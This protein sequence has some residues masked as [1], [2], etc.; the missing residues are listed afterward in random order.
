MDG[1][2]RVW[3]ESVVGDEEHAGGADGDERRIVRHRADA[4]GRRG[5]VAAATGNDRPLRH[6][7][8]LRH[9][10][11]QPSRC[12]RTFVELRHLVDAHAAGGKQFGRPVALGDIEPVGA[13]RVRHVGGI[14]AR[15]AEAD[16]VLGQKHLCHLRKNLGLMLLH[17]Q[18]LRRGEAGKRDVAGNLAGARLRLLDVV[19][20]PEGTR[21]VPQ[22]AGPQ[23]LA[24]LAE[25]CRAMLLA[26][27]PDA[28]DRGDGLG[29]QLA[30]RLHHRV[31][32][33][34]PVLGVLLRPAGLRARD[35]QGGGGGG[36][37]LLP[38]VD[39][40]ALHR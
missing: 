30:Q 14:F 22:N 25:Q 2:A 7:P 37:D 6:A 34:P 29:L 9:M 40:D 20:F 26:G 5:I 38:G 17:P 36:D 35:L 27:Q 39:Q 24:V 12:I 32:G 21:V 16:V 31:A 8:G 19:A 3:T 4:A 33:L 23:G 18:Q 1:A 13:G 15:H 10:R 28:L 11:R